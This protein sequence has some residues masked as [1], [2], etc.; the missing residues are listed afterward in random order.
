MTP[1]SSASPPQSHKSIASGWPLLFALYRWLRS[2]C[3][4]LLG[5]PHAAAWPK[6]GAT[7][8]GCIVFM[9]FLANAVFSWP[10]TNALIRNS[11]WSPFQSPEVRDICA[12]DAGGER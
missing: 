7:L 3:S 2:T 11:T 1:S 12:S 9:L 6:I 5:K 8:C 4:Q 10:R